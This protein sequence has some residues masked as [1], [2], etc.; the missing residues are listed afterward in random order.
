MRATLLLAGAWLIAGPMWPQTDSSQNDTGIQI[1]GV[2]HEIGLNLGLP[3]AEV[4]IF[5]FAGPERQKTVFAIAATDPRGEF[6]FHP[7]RFG[8]YWIE[9]KK[10]AYF[11]SIPVE[12]ISGSVM[13]PPPHEETGTL[14]TV[15]AAHPSQEVRFAL[16]RPGALTGTLVDEADKPLAGALIE[17]SMA[18]LPAFV[19]AAAKTDRDG[20][21]TA[22]MLMPGEYLVKISPTPG[23]FLNAPP[24]FSDDDL[25]V[26]DEGLETFYWPDAPDERSATPARV[27][28]GAS[29]N[30]GNVRVRATPSY[31]ARVSMEG[32][33]PDDLPYLTVV[34]PNDGTVTI[35]NDG[36]T[37]TV[38][39]PTF[40]ASPVASC[41]DVL[42]KGLKPGAYTF[43][44]SGQKGWAVAAVEVA[45]KNLEVSLAMSPAVEV[46]GRFVAPEGG[47]LPALDKVHITLLPAASG[48]KPAQVPAPDAKG[49]F[50]AAN[51]MGPSHRVGV[52]GLGEKYYVK[53]IRV[54]GKAAPDGVAQLYQGSQ[55]E[56]VLD[57]QPAAITG[58]VTEGDKPFS[59]P[60]VFVAKWPSLAVATPRPTTGDNS[61][62]FQITG[63]Q[64]GEYRVLAVPST[65]LP[66]GQ[67]IPQSMLGKLWNDAERITLERGGSKAVALKLSDP[68][69]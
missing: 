9:V 37:M 23:K 32:C 39:L 45:K 17:I 57:D 44:L 8:D 62:Q 42:V 15:S 59:Q 7:V 19:R 55:I 51:V 53:E 16:M 67:Q 34:T 66:D 52:N 65:P 22:R 56:I 25:K 47:T 69:R 48:G 38:P 5:E 28:P 1:H 36:G 27:T 31:R 24:K 13:A 33:K 14:I 41:A 11:A 68:L 12:G 63:L 21:F 3:G 2:V 43:L 50:S 64:P 35:Q 6:N 18:G 58:L 54:D 4:T 29:T 61:G 30:L 26:V 60:L 40:F 10:Q 20:V 46:N 49:A